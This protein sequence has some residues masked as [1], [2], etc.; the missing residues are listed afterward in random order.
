MTKSS[1]AGLATNIQEHLQQARELGVELK[2]YAQAYGVDI[3]AL[4]EEERRMAREGLPTSES[5]PE[6]LSDFV[7]VQVLPDTP[8]S[9]PVSTP[10]K[11]C[12]RLQHPSGWELVCHEWPTG[13]WL[14]SLPGVR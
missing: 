12:C 5:A 9:E 2:E 11:V 1:T 13:E 3:E 6:K 10:T 7:Q 8:C 14:A 4:H